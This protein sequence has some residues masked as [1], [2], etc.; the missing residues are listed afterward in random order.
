MCS[1][2]SLLIIAGGKSSR[3]KIDKR[4]IEING[5]SL[6][7][8]L[9]I[10]ASKQGFAEI[11]LCVEEELEFIEKLSVKYDAKILVDTIK[12]SGPISGLTEG[13]KNIR[14]DWALAISCDMPFF[15][16]EV[17]ETLM[18]ELGNYEVVMFEQQP[19]A[20]FYHKTMA[21]NFS[22]AL[23]EDNRKLRNIIEQVPH[24][25]LKSASD[26]SFFNVNTP[27]DL[28][29]ARG[30]AANLQRKVP[31]ISIVA[32][33]SG[34]GKTTFIEKLIPKLSARGIRVG[35]VKSDAH[36]FNLDVEG[37]DSWRFSQ[38][39]AKSVAVVS[40]KGW[41][42]VQQTETRADF[43]QIANKM[44]DVDLILTESRSHGTIPAISLYRNLGEIIIN[45]TVAAI[46]TI[47][48]FDVDDILQIN[49][50]DTDRAL[51]LCLFLMGR[52][53]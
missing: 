37:K 8:N 38:A 47:R 5:T 1:K 31:I 28:R 3:M 36:G 16:F 35:V 53:A 9:L 19:L 44:E 4:L 27:A 7:E 39:G 50:D 24:K 46:F 17:V 15:E 34:T 13:L 43:S 20:A 22:K 41:L 48:E 11:F 33:S 49:L 45:E 42:M 6:L 23:D 18:N 29:L 2:V 32:P 25:I 26:D 14:S 40:P 52:S 12:N 30:R 21:E 10:K 51:K